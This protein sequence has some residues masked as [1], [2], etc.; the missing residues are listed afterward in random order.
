[1]SSYPPQLLSQIRYTTCPATPHLRQGHGFPS[2]PI[3]GFTSRPRE[4]A[5]GLRHRLQ[6]AW[7]HSSS[8]RSPVRLACFLAPVLGRSRHTARD[9][10]AAVTEGSA[11]TMALASPNPS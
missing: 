6:T 11:L 5:L 7:S 8:G 10:S 2:R 1:M 3:A 4:L 9:R